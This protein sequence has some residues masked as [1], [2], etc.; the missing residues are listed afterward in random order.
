MAYWLMDSPI[1]QISQAPLK[2]VRDGTNYS[3]DLGSASIRLRGLHRQ[4]GSNGSGGF[5]RS[6]GSRRTACPSRLN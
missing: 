3:R 1:N 4:G 6:C 2:G 5:S